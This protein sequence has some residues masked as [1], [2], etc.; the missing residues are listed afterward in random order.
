M[1][2]EFINGK[3]SIFN[4]IIFKETLSFGILR[5]FVLD[6]YLSMK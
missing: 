2:L 6:R 1:E 3:S 4:Q 5:I